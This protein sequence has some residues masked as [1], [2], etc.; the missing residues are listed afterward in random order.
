MSRNPDIIVIGS[1]LNGLA[2]ALALGGRHVKRPLDVVVVDAK[3]P[4]SFFTNAFDGRASAITAAAR[5]MFEALGVWQKVAHEAQPMAEII[6]T[7]SQRPGDARPVLL[8]FDAGDMKGGP[9]AHMIENRHLYAAMYEEA[10]A[11]PHIRSPVGHAVE[12]DGFGTGLAALTL[13][14]GDM[15]KAALIVA[16]DGRNS[17]ARAAAGIRMI[18]WPMTRWHWWRLSNT[19]CR[20]MA[21]PRNI[22][23]HR[24]PSPSCRCP[25]TAPHWSGRRGRPRASACWPCLRRNSRPNSACASAS[26]WDR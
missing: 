10:E 18:G 23:R 21:V 11:S 15:L 24:A 1:A 9:S 19:N 2:A 16:A 3:D 6:V 12:H 22:S 26:T 7:D 17:P 8:Q 25:A 13:E 14:G 4:R 5:R 20:I